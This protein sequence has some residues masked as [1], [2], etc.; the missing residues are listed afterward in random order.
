MRTIYGKLTAM[1]LAVTLGLMLFLPMRFGQE[2]HLYA[3][4]HS[5]RMNRGDTYSITCT[6]DSDR[7]QSVGY[8]SVDENVA[9]VDAKGQVKAVGPGTTD[10]HISASGGAKTSVR[11]EVSGVPT[12]KLVLNTDTLRMEKGQ[13]TGL[14]ASFNE[15]A[16]DTRLEWASADSEIAK[17]DAAG[18]VTALR[19]G[20]TQVYAT[21]PN[22]LRAAADVFVHVS[23]DAMRMTP[24]DLTVGT[25]A[26]LTIG[27]VWF[28]DDTT[29]TVERWV[30]SDERLLTVDADGTIH[31]VG[32]GKPVLTVYSGEGLSSSAVINVEQSAEHFDLSPTTA[33]IE[34]GDTLDLQTRFFDAEGNPYPA[35][36]DHYITWV[37]SNPEVATVDNGHV[38]ALKSGQTVISATVDGQTASCALQVQVL[39][40]EITLNE[41]E[42]YML[43]SATYMPIQ[44]IATIRPDD[45]DD[46][47][48]TW[49]TD[50]DLVATVDEN[51]LVTLTGGYGTAVITARAVSGAEAHFTVSVVVKLPEVDDDTG[52]IVTPAV[53]AA[54]ED[55]G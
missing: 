21:T 34:R 45:P 22:G 53:T 49:L 23:G 51:G 50:N 47:T 44:L 20:Q 15:G 42:I 36:E 3:Y 29:D 46:P 8:A 28:P 48:I 7:A 10:I 33:T 5:I 26:S 35:S 2:D 16:D 1:I 12:T 6:L 52:E 30:S 41:H 43:K 13:A 38:E 18:R 40:H 25:G 19:G 55:E 54:E 37:S 4:P 31:A 39:V 24:E 11:V 32:V 17:V 9:T 14:S 27:P